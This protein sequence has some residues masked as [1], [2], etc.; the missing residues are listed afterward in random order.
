M[1]Q[2]NGRADQTHYRSHHLEHCR[3]SFTPLPPEENAALA[4]SKRFTEAR[5]QSESTEDFAQHVFQN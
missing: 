3:K 5:A 2:E 1:G 4:Q